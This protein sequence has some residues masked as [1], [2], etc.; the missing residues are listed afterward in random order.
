MHNQLESWQ[1]YNNTRFGVHKNAVKQ[2]SLLLKVMRMVISGL[3]DS[4]TYIDRLDWQLYL[5]EMKSDGHK[6]RIVKINT[7]VVGLWV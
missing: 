5:C 1:E 7:W 6:R 4:I 2:N 3:N